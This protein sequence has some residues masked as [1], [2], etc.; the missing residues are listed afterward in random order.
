MVTIQ[1][2]DLFQH[3]TPPAPD[4]G[5]DDDDN[6]SDAAWQEKRI[7]RLFNPM[8]SAGVD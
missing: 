2:N 6:M 1:L 3:T 4:P 7:Q 5:P 8:D